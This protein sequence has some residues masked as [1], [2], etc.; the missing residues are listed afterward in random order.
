MLLATSRS[1]N[2]GPLVRSTNFQVPSVVVPGE[3]VT[4]F[5]FDLAYNDAWWASDFPLPI[6]GSGGRQSTIRDAPQVS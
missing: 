1:T 6:E 5:G 2:P 4:L 3:F